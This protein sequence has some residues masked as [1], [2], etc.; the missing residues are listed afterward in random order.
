MTLVE[1]VDHSTGEIE[2]GRFYE[3]PGF[4]GIYVVRQSKDWRC[5]GL[6]TQRTC[7]LKVST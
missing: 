3:S 1:L 7:A 2:R 6:P 4:E 5:S